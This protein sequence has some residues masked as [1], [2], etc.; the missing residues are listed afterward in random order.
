MDECERGL[1]AVHI[2]Q[3]DISF[4]AMLKENVRKY[5]NICSSA[6]LKREFLRKSLKNPT[7]IDGKFARPSEKKRFMSR[8]KMSEKRVMYTKER[9]RVRMSENSE[10]IREG[11]LKGFIKRDIVEDDSLVK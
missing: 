5:P 10:L 2:N 6:L 7:C 3:F 1:S 4:R 9:L 11:V 8:L